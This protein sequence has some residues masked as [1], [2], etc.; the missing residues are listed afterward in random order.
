[1]KDIFCSYY[2]D[3]KDITSYMV[4]MLQ[5]KDGDVLLEPAVG[6][7]AFI[8]E[9]L[10][11][12]KNVVIDA[13]DIDEKALDVLKNKIVDK[14]KRNYTSNIFSKKISKANNEI[15][16]GCVD[17]LTNEL[18]DSF[19]ET[20]GFYSKIIGNPPYGAWQDLNRRAIL[21]KKYN[22]AYVKETYSLFLLRCISLL[23]E[24][25]ILSFIIPDTFLFLNMHTKL[26]ECLLTQTKIHEI[27]IFPSKFFPGISF[28]Y[29]N[30]SII[31]VEKRSERKDNLRNKFFV[32]KNFKS[33][34][35]FLL[36]KNKRPDY[37][38]KYECVQNDVLKND[39]HRFLLSDDN[40][41]V[42]SD[43]VIGDVA[44]V[45]TGFYS[46]DNKRFVRVAKETVKGSKGYRLIE[47]NKIYD[48]D[49]LIGVEKEEAYVPYIKSSSPTK[50]CRLD[51]D[52]FV[53]WDKA[54]VQFYNE[55][56]K[57]RFQNSSFY[58]KKGIGIPM[59][60]SSVIRAFLMEG[61]VFDQSIVG[62][63]PK[64]KSKFYYLL[65]LMNSDVVNKLIHIIN[66]TANN[67]SNYVKRIPYLEPSNKK[68]FDEISKSTK[69]I[70]ECMKKEQFEEAKILHDFV[71]SKIS[72]VYKFFSAQS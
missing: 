33:T 6:E 64:E 48:S 62:I 34:R 2:T 28:G 55:N 19:A 67:S 23:K 16:I 1:M 49:S 61:M 35:E 41:F 4:S 40:S 31:T 45:V 53:R 59:V 42:N 21:K 70:F 13:A 63:F 72:G 66:P 22:G 39:N 50:Y 20:S 15:R 9:V 60:K 58:F 68:D 37:V 11:R 57:S 36:D 43:V 71:N 24:G 8:Q 3:S 47:K 46:G 7:G 56:K 25:G 65:A 32:C 51:N 69:R 29:S 14:F 38:K 10:E 18:L 30:L 17:S 52:W 27:L 26:R 44:D 5:L 12:K 54:T